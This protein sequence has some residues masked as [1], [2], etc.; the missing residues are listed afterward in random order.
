MFKCDY[1]YLDDGEESK[2]MNEV[3]EDEEITQIFIDRLCIPLILSKD[4]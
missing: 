4:R 2:Q 1:L 3:W